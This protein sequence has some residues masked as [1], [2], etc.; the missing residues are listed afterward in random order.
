MR[1]VDDLSLLRQRELH[2]NEPGIINCWYFKMIIVHRTSNFWCSL[3]LVSHISQY[4][5]ENQSILLFMIVKNFLLLLLFSTLLWLLNY[6]DYLSISY[7]NKNYLF[8][9]FAIYFNKRY[10]KIL[11]NGIFSLRYWYFMLSNFYIFFK[12]NVNF[13]VVVVEIIQG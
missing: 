8:A 5:I 11:W 9:Y 4:I 7:F 2:K 13:A 10:L 1:I 12:R 3:V 6:H